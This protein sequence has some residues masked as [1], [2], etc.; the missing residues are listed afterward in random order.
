MIVGLGELLKQGHY[1]LPSLQEKVCVKG[2]ITGEGIKVMEEELGD[3]FEHIFQATHTKFNED[4][5]KV[6]SQFYKH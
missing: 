3:L 5:E 2:G 1:T 6:N 4:L